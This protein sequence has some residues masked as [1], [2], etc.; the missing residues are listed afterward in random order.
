M[1]QQ[2]ESAH[3]SGLGWGFFLRDT[4]CHIKNIKYFFCT[5]KLVHLSTF[6]LIVSY[7]LEIT[8]KETSISDIFPY[9]SLSNLLVLFYHFIHD[10][11]F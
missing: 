1:V 6:K 3:Q 11:Q 5:I 8:D 10:F 7:Q 2:L 9:T 4:I